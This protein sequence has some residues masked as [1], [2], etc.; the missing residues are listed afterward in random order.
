MVEM[1]EMLPSPYQAPSRPNTAWLSLDAE[2]G[3]GFTMGTHV[4]GRAS[5]IRCPVDLS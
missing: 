5:P 4:T 1:K 2:A 3:S